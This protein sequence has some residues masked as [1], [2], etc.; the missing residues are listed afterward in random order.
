MNSP[1]KRLRE[2]VR[3]P[4]LHPA[5]VAVKVDPD[6]FHIRGGPWSGPAYTLRDDDEDSGLGRLP[7]LLDGSNDV[8][9]VLDHFEADQQEEIARVLLEMTEIDLVVDDSTVEE[10]WP[11]DAIERPFS[12]RNQERLE[13]TDVTVISVGDVGRQIATDLLD[14]GVD[15]VRFL[16]LES[17]ASLD[18][19]R[20]RDRFVDLA[21]EGVDVTEAVE[22]AEF[23]VYA[24]EEPRPDLLREIND[25]ALETS[26]PWHLTQV[27]GLDG[28]VGPTILPGETAC[29]EC[30]EQRTL[31][32]V[33]EP[34]GYEAYLDRHPDSEALAHRKLAPLSR[35]VAGYAVLDLMNYFSFGRGFTTGRVITVDGLD[36]SVETNDVLQLPRCPSCGTRPGQEVQRF[37]SDRDFS[38][39]VDDEEG[40]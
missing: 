18:A 35:Q 38:R 39:L 6:T 16:Q 11:H 8:D 19:L 36:L 1:V 37:I 7:S 24:A 10:A 31:A 13:S 4:V 23:V 22:T 40:S 12:Q 5:F 32:N 26:T 34:A 2:R 9:E 20:D 14:V 29:Y 25:Q 30:F 15:S 21:A 33:A 17:G 28:I 27:Y 3:R